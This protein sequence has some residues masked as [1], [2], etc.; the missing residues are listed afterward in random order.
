MGAPFAAGTERVRTGVQDGCGGNINEV[1]ILGPV[2][3]LNVPRGRPWEARRSAIYQT[4]RTA[5]GDRR[6]FERTKSYGVPEVHGAHPCMQ[7]SSVSCFR[8]PRWD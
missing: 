5:L 1:E 6:G 4:R 7:E 2:D 3:L 8:G